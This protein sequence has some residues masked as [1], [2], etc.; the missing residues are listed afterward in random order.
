M[1][2]DKEDKLDVLCE[3]TEALE[4]YS[5]IEKV[6]EIDTSDK[7]NI[8]FSYDNR[9]KISFGTFE[10]ADTKVKFLSEMLGKDIWRDSTGEID[11]SNPSEALVKFTGNVAN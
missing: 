7:F 8:K 4:K 1:A 2:F 6:T 10:K 3:V 5:M 9:F 11:I